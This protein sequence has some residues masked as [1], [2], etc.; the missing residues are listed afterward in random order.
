[1]ETAAAE[2]ICCCLKFHWM[3]IRLSSRMSSMLRNAALVKKRAQKIRL[4]SVG[5]FEPQRKNQPHKRMNQTSSKLFFV[6]FYSFRV[7][8]LNQISLSVFYN[9]TNVHSLWRTWRSWREKR[10]LVH[11]SEYFKACSCVCFGFIV[12]GK[13]CPHIDQSASK[14]NVTASLGISS[15]ASSDINFGTFAILLSAI[16]PKCRE[17]PSPPTGAARGFKQGALEEVT[18]RLSW[19][20]S[21]N[22]HFK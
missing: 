10:L 14:T 8:S 2:K 11:S 12:R 3:L 18:S 13:L 6:S 9:F 20:D 21:K 4:L 7:S 1:M 19:A 16:R 17:K 22:I 5:F 15:L